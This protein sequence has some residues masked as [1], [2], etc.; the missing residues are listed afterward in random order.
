MKKISILLA[1]ILLMMCVTTVLAD[2]PADVSVSGGCSTLNAQMPVL[3]SV[4]LVSNT[5]AAI[6]YETNTDTLMYA[7]N[8]DTQ[9]QPASLLK[10]MTALIA[11]EKGSM[12]DAVTVRAETLD[13]LPVDAAVVGLEIDEVLTVN[14]L[15]YCMMVSSGND[16]AVVLAEHIMGTQEAF[17]AEMNR[18]AAELGCKGTNFTNVTGLYDKNQ[19]TTARD[20]ARILSKAIENAQFQ[21]VFG[22]KTYDV[23][24]S[25]KSEV[26]N[27]ATQ[28]YLINNDRVE[29]YYDERV[30][31]GRTA[32]NNDRTRSVASTAQS[33][34]M[35]LI[36]I[37]IGSRSQFE[38]DGYTEKVFG[39]YDETKQLLD[40]AFNGYKTAQVLFAGQILQQNSVL[41]GNCDVSVGI[42]DPVY[43]VIPQ[44]MDLNSLD[45]RYADDG[46]LNAPVEKGQ[47]LS[48]LQ[49]WNG[50]ICIGQ[51]DTYAMNSV[52]VA[53]AELSEDAARNG[54]TSVFV[55][56]LC[57]LGGFFVAILVAFLI[58]FC[59]RRYR[60]AKVKVQNRQLSRNRRRSR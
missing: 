9:V 6:L 27:L 39:G 57:V 41:N 60:I 32:V 43:S 4:Q 8:A 7:Y 23:P 45:F 50:P 56:I 35:D 42:K 16:A 13:I 20:V 40:L 26:R 44:N 29:I 34:G 3:G 15:L 59:L 33:N 51:T 21:Q 30:T 22:T 19:Y 1:A 11:V 12:D 28:N 52:A 53:G 55:I 10:I 49:I 54:K 24:K 2:T 47:K 37:V 46:G 18:Y 38:K 31:G 36:C 5:A 58:L 25:N 14:D 17:V 48:S